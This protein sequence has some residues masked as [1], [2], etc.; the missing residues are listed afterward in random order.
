MVQP[1]ADGLAFR[2]RRLMM[3]PAGGEQALLV[4]RLSFAHMLLATYLHGSAVADNLIP[5][6]R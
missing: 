2:E 6:P 3:R 5:P 1:L 4:V